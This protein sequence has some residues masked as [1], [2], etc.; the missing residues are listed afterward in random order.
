MF[1]PFT[2]AEATSRT[3]SVREAA[4]AANVT[5]YQVE[6][7]VSRG[8]IKTSHNPVPPEPRIYSYF[9][10]LSIASFASL[11]LLGYP[12]SKYPGKIMH[13]E[14]F[15]GQGFLD[16]GVELGVLACWRGPGYVLSAAP[17]SGPSPIVKTGPDAQTVASESFYS[18]I[19][20]LSQVSSVLSDPDKWAVVMVNLAHV[21]ERVLTKLGE[22][23]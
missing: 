20:D 2:R 6:S 1:Q 23:A 15:L 12:A 11:M 5:R 10:I 3:Y 14:G 4:D 7:W 16:S 18:R 21:E 13:V 9:D 22:A 17:P 8:F 19:F